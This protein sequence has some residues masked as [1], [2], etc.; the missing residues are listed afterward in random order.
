MGGGFLLSATSQTKNPTWILRCDDTHI[1]QSNSSDLF[2]YDVVATAGEVQ[3]PGHRTLI[4]SIASVVKNII[5]IKRLHTHKHILCL[6]WDE[7][8][9]SISV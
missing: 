2:G 6:K 8:L 1:V 9:T 5:I 4:V 7:L 3:R